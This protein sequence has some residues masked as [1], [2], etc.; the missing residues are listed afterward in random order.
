MSVEIKHRQRRMRGPFHLRSLT[1]ASL[2][3]LHRWYFDERCCQKHAGTGKCVFPLH[4]WGAG[5]PRGA[6]CPWSGAGGHGCLARSA[7]AGWRWLRLP[8]TSRV[9]GADEG[10]K[11]K[12]LL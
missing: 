2:F 4:A 9:L 11:K 1:A 5:C 7:E 6:G 10:G 8:G 12:K 3:S